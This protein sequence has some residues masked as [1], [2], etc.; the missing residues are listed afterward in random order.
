MVTM[1]SAPRHRLA[2]VVVQSLLTRIDIAIRKSLAVT[3]AV[4]QMARVDVVST[5]PSKRAFVFLR[6]ELL[7]SVMILEVM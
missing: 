2:L 7:G 6:T 5:P 4:F 3:R 1:T